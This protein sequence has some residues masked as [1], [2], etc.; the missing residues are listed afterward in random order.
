MIKMN[1]NID[2]AIEKSIRFERPDYIPMTFHINNACWTAYPQEALWDL[3][4]SHPFLFPDFV[5][6]KDHFVPSYPNVAR[7]DQPY[8]DDWGCTWETTMDGITGTVTKHPLNDWSNYETY[9]FPDPEVCM[10]IGS[11]DW[12]EEK[13]I[14]KAQKENKHFVNRGL[15][16]GHTFLQITDI[17]G[18]P[19]PADLRF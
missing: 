16:H 9:R 4:E 3:M 1:K 19:L 10:G 7:K 6:P 17:C 11:I 12:E 2:K 8:V 14:I 13:R 18:Y 5:R 15:R